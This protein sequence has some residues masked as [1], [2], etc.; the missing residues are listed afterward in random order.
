L[1]L[2]F[3]T[4]YGLYEWTVAC[5]GLKNAPAEF[6]RY[7]S[8]VLRPF[9]TD[10]VVVYFNDIIIF[11]KGE[12][13]HWEQI[14]KILKRLQEVKINLKITKCKFKVTETEFL[15]HIINGKTM[16]MQQEKI[17]TILEWP[18]STN[19]EEIYFENWLAITWKDS[20]TE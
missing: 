20:R 3:I 9:L 15:G 18:T 1:D 14:K 10:F 16:K 8:N 7:M 19:N 2:A 11:S 6:A 5:S 13:E 4:Q 12:E 17:K